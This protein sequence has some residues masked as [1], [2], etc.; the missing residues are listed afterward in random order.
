MVCLDVVVVAYASGN[1]T[2]QNDLLVQ[3]A[4]DNV[5]TAS[6]ARFLS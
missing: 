2:N 6:I 5:C 1:N 3:K 4:S